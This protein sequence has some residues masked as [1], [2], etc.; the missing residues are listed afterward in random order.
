MT[1]HDF[2]ATHAD[3]LRLLL[4]EVVPRDEF[5]SAVDSGGFEYLRRMLR[6]RPDWE[7]RIESL[8]ADPENAASHEDWPWFAALVAAGYYADPANGGNS[9][10]AS[11][12]M[13]GWRRAPAGGWPVDVPVAEARRTVIGPAEL[14]DRYDAIVIGSGAGGGVAA[15][16]LAEQG[17]RVLVV[18][19]GPWP[20][21]AELSADHIRNPR[22]DWGVA[23]LSGPPD[24]GNPR[25]LDDGRVRVELRP[26]DYPWSNNAM[27]A[28]GGTRVYGAQAWR[29]APL[30]FRM[31][32]TYGTP[33]GSSLADWPISY[34]DLEHYYSRAER[35]IGVSGDSDG[36]WSG[37]RSEPFPM[38]PLPSGTQRARLQGAA[39]SLG[40]ST[41]HVPLLINST[42]YL[43]RHA[44]AQCSMCVGFACPVDAKNGSQNTML[45]RAFAT[46]RCVI[47]LESRAVRLRTDATGRVVGVTVRGTGAGDSWEREVDA[48]EVVVAAGAV[49]SARLLLASTSDREPN[50]LGNN[51]DQVGRHLQ[52]HVYGG[53][54]ALFDDVVEEFIG[55]G[56]SIATTDFRHGNEG[57]VGGGMIANEFVALPANVYGYL[58]SA[59]LLPLAGLESKH[60]MRDLSRRMLRLM[61]PIQEVTMADSRVRVDPA[62]VDATGMPVAVLSGESTARTSRIGPSSPRRAR[63]GCVPPARAASLRWAVRRRSSCAAD[64]AAGSTRPAPAGWAT[65]RR[66]ASSTRSAASGGTTICVSPTVPFT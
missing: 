28:G 2:V 55:P 24:D 30:D 60:G 66:R 44:C 14:H 15:C 4:D 39:D 17:R 46:G 11:W 62:T 47:L 5:P 63:S 12:S 49:E 21:I 50:G 56:P 13:I 59:G 19:S 37:G 16:G 61:G 48:A 18:E 57:L 31:A 3:A 9:D 25:V 36:S 1:P 32:S 53:A 51:A 8:I 29:F 52:A 23:P 54:T 42:P 7:T 20:S 43:G 40:I 34:D 35:E 33:D 10:A 45:T 38:P 64:R 26:S 41:V 22:S 27:T 65:I 6:E 58:V